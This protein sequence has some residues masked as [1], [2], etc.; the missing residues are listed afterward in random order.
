MIKTVRIYRKS[1]GIEPFTQ[2][3]NKI[4]DETVKA[5]IRRRIDRLYFGNE[6]DCKLVGQGVFELRLD[7]GAGYRVY[8][9]K[10]DDVII[11]LLSGG[12]KKS[13]TKDIQLAKQYWKEL[14]ENNYE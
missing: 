5:R 4:K 6:G 2:W 13:Q 10:V 12:D 14:K 3:I 9:G 7:F 11:V 1:S 8:Y